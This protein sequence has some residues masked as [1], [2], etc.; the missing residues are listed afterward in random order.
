MVDSFGGTDSSNGTYGPVGATSG[1]SPGGVSGDPFAG[2]SSGQI[3]FMGLDGRVMGSMNLTFDQ[4]ANIFRTQT[5][6]FRGPGPW[7]DVKAWGAVG[8]GVADDTAAIQ[9]AIDSLGLGGTVF[10]PP[11]SYRTSAT[12]LM[13]DRNLTMTLTAGATLTIGSSVISMFTVPDGLTAKRLYILQGGA[14]SAGSVGGQV[15]AT[16]SDSKG[17]GDFQI[18]ETTISGFE[19]VY[20]ITDGDTVNFL[21]IVRLYLF[22][23]KCNPTASASSKLV[24]DPGTG[25]FPAEAYLRNID[26]LDTSDFTKGWA[27]TGDVDTYIED[28]NIGVLTSSFGNLVVNDSNLASGNG[29]IWTIAGTTGYGAFSDLHNASLVNVSPVINTQVCRLDNVQISR[30]NGTDTPFVTV[31]SKAVRI[32]NSTF[33]TAAARAIDIAAGAT[34]VVVCGCHFYAG[35]ISS[36]YIRT[37]STYGTYTG[38]TFEAP[39]VLKKT[40]V[41]IA[42]ANRNVVVGCTGINQS[43]GTTWNIN[44]NSL[45]DTTVANI[46]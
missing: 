6:Q 18:Q 30:L 11:G 36:E 9:A 44:G 27:F 25:A 16:I 3:L 24:E 14:V 4:L 38:L 42:G 37:A 10:F 23:S 20:K 15:V 41:E 17:L 5:G 35:G 32:Q 21:N 33:N 2:I 40:L 45:A 43:G 31:N 7:A 29:A 22:V 46:A 39:P 28:S 19:K 26:G 12:L 34:H 8:D 1:S 13:P